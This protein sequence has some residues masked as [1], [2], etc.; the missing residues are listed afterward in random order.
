MRR[1]RR[2]MMEGEGMRREEELW[3]E[4]RG[5]G[6]TWI[7]TRGVGKRRGR[8]RGKDGMIGGVTGGREIA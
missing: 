8:G 7:K 3:G 6:T 1:R 5:D 4:E 2:E